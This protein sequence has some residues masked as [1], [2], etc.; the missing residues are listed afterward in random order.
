MESYK[1]QM[2]Q[3]L[4]KPE[5]FQSLLDAVK[6]FEDV[7][8]QLLTDFWKQTEAALALKA[9]GSSWKVEMSST[10]HATHSQLTIFRG[11]WVKQGGHPICTLAYENLCGHLFYGLWLNWDAQDPKTVALREGARQ[12]RVEGFK[13]DSHQWWPWWA[14]TTPNFTNADAFSEILP[15]VVKDTAQQTATDLFQLAEKYGP[16]I[17]RIIEKS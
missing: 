6:S 9:T 15:L 1:Q 11:S 16:E 5:N 17:D 7:K 3:F 10:I 8:K 4:T 13:I 14:H 12:M 2:F